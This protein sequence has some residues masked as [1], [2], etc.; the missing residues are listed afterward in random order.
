MSD[1]FDEMEDSYLHVQHKNKDGSMHYDGVLGTF[2]YDTSMFE[3]HTVEVPETE[4]F[5]AGQY[6][7]LRYIGDETD[8]NKIKIPEGITNTSLMFM[9]SDITSMPKIPDG[10][11]SADSM[12][13]GCESLRVANQRFPKSLNSANFM[14][15]G[16]MA[17]E[18]GPDVVPG[19]ITDANFMFAGCEN[20][21]NIPKFTDGIESGEFMFSNC[22]SLNDTPKIPSSMR[23]YSGMTYGCTGMD[24]KT[25]ELNEARMARKRAS[26]ES[27]LNKK[28]FSE[29]VGSGFG[30]IMQC[31]AL[32]QAG[33]GFIMAP[34]MTHIM[35]KN[36]SFDKSLSGGL[37]VS[38]VRR[39]GLT[40]VL[41]GGLA[42]K[43]DKHGEKSRA[44][45]AEKL[46]QF[47]RM[48]DTV[49]GK[50]REQSLRVMKKAGKD[51]ESGLFSRMAGMSSTEKI[52]YR[53]KYGGS[54]KTCE[55]AMDKVYAKT[56]HTMTPV[57]R[58]AISEWYQKQ[59]AACAAYY[60]EAERSIKAKF[61]SGS[62]YDKAMAGLNEVSDMQVGSLLSSIE[63]VQKKYQL[64]N[65]GDIRN[66]ARMVKDMPCEKERADSFTVRMLSDEDIYDSMMKQRMAF[67]K[68]NVVTKDG[69][70]KE[71]SDEPNNG[72]DKGND[73]GKN[74]ER[75]AT[76]SGKSSKW[77]QAAAFFGGSKGKDDAQSS[78]GFSL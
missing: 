75:S 54:Y 71:Y 50:N 7:V 53:E 42:G 20:M 33:Y 19:T 15:F 14:F 68:N 30:A 76:G 57:E 46:S 9:N 65:D 40:G 60:G 23:E 41:L 11:E 77:E 29:K 44:K 17:M 73:S 63:A 3:L 31:H 12:F 59:V 27:K 32:R 61:K 45:S 52:P 49:Q 5:P 6:E 43:I 66:I 28:T 37:A 67:V 21:K 22:K 36:G 62:E 56:G 64:F 74:R 58:H 26:L 39:G 25:D 1:T 72:T 18:K 78:A 2:D 24:A 47:D 48:A 35:R 55:K 34:I 4:D 38:A 70:T 13:S 10:V 8:G 69:A 51:V 16:C